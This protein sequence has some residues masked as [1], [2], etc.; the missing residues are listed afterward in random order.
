MT[1]LSA[2]PNVDCRLLKK[3]SD[4]IFFEK[5][6]GVHSVAQDV[7]E[8]NTAANWLLFVDEVLRDVSVPLE[9][10]LLHR[11]DFETSG[12]MVAARNKKSFAYLKEL[13]KKNLVTKEYVCLVSTPG[14]KS[15]RYEAYAY[16][17]G[18]SS[19]K[20][21][22]GER[23]GVPD[24]AKKIITVVKMVCHC[25]RDEVKRGNLP[26]KLI[27]GDRHGGLRP[28]RDD[29]QDIFRIT[30]DI[31]TG[32]RHQIRAHLAFLGFPLVGDVLYGGEPA[33]RIMLHAKRLEFTLGGI[34]YNVTC[35][36]VF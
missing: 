29:R 7:D 25:E 31:H 3:N 30:L 12:V 22:V 5:G 23:D 19:K 4:Y 18:K 13:F 36:E 33:L 16:G 35:P 2:N 9:S 20:V 28:P 14:L 8:T 24:E 6:S 26:D 10:G 27:I 34:I 32:F 21:I 11:L 17:R 15:G 1:T